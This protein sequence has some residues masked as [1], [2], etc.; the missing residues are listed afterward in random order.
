[1]RDRK[2]EDNCLRRMFLSI[3]FLFEKPQPE[4]RHDRFASRRQVDFRQGPGHRRARRSSALPRRGLPQQRGTSRRGGRTAAGPSGGRRVPGRAGRRSGLDGDLAGDL[5]GAGHPDRPL[6]AACSRSARAGSASSSWPSSRSP[7]ARKVALKIIKPGMDTREV[8]ARFEAER[9]ALA[10]MDHPNIAQVFDGGATDSGPAVLR[11]GA[12]QG[13][14]DHRVLRREQL[15][16]PRNGLRLFV[17][18][19]QAVQ[20]AHQKGVIHRDLKPSNIMVTLHDG[21]PVAKVIDFGVAKALSQRLTEQDAVHGVRPDDRHA[22]VHEPRAGGDERAGR[23]H[24]ERHLLAG[25][26]AVRTADR[27]H[28]VG[29]E[30]RCAKRATPRCSGSS[31][32]R[33]AAAQRAAEHARASG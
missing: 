22:A 2:I 4:T 10:L 32:R 19:C 13:R 9:Q 8:V 6:Q 17:D 7:C 21:K 3:I 1:M 30:P 14:A 31:A 12:G 5:R 15:D 11:D 33:A 16:R 18:V 27:E 20:H 23:R 28:A 26:A 29:G 24:A 25:R